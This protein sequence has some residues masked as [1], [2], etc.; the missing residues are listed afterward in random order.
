MAQRVYVFVRSHRF[1]DD[2]KQYM[3]SMEY[4][5]VHPSSDT[6]IITQVTKRCLRKLFKDGIQ[7]KKVGVMLVD[8]NV[9]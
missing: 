8:C 7:Y 3:N 4:K 6:R 5:L 2:L 1:R 9:F